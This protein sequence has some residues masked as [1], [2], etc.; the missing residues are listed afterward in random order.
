[1]LRSILEFIT[2]ILQAFCITSGTQH[3]KSSAEELKDLNPCARFLFG[4]HLIRNLNM[5]HRKELLD[6]GAFGWRGLVVGIASAEV[7]PSGALL[8]AGVIV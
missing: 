8:T 1:M 6:L 2:R 7:D 3:H 5:N 4:G